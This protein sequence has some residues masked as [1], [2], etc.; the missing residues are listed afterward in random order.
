MTAAD[1][2]RDPVRYEKKPL[3]S[4]IFNNI[5]VALAVEVFREVFNTTKK[6]VF[7]APRLFWKLIKSFPAF[8]FFELFPFIVL[9]SPFI[10]PGILWF[11]RSPYQALR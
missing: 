6:M 11:L 1:M 10:F 9:T 3:P 8:F 5:F 7:G 2:S 4:K